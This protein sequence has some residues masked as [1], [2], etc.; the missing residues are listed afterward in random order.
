MAANSLNSLRTTEKLPAHRVFEEK[1]DF[2]REQ[3]GSFWEMHRCASGRTQSGSRGS[4]RSA[5]SEEPYDF[6]LY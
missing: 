5:P 2:V 1:I 3:L 6:T 4:G